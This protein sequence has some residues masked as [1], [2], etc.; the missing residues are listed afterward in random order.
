[1]HTDF[2]INLS[3]YYSVF[4]PSGRTASA[5]NDELLFCNKSVQT[6]EKCFTDDVG[7][8]YKEQLKVF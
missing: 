8:T 3:I 5:I 6:H 2:K 1:M 4:L 7:K